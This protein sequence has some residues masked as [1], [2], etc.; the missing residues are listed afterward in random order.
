MFP[1]FLAFSVLAF[2]DGSW[3]ASLW[4]PNMRSS[5]LSVRQYLEGVAGGLN[6]TNEFGI[7]QVAFAPET[8]SYYVIATAD[9]RIRFR[10]ERNPADIKLDSPKSS[11]RRGHFF[12]CYL[13]RRDQRDSRVRVSRLSTI[14][15][16]VVN[17]TPIFATMAQQGQ[18]DY[19]LFG[20]SLTRNGSGTLAFGAID[21]SVVV[22]RSLI[23]YLHWAIELSGIS[24]NG[25]EITPIPTYP[26]ATSNASLALI[27]V[28]TPGIYGPYQDVSRIFSMIQDARL[29][30][31]D[32]QWVVPCDVS[33][34]ISFNFGGE[35]FT[36]QPTDYLIGP[37]SGNPDLCLT[38]PRAL[39]PS[40]DGLDW[41]LG[42][43]FLRTVYSIFSFGINTKEAP[44]IGLYPLNNASAPIESPDAVASF[45]SSASATI[46]TALP[47]FV[48]STPTF[49]TPPYAFNTS[50]KATPG[51]IVTSGLATSTYSAVLGTRTRDAT[52]LPTV[53]PSPTI[54]TL[55]QTDSSGHTITSV[56][57]AS[58]PSVTLGIPPGWILSSG[59]ATS[60]PL[61]AVLLGIP[62]LLFALFTSDIL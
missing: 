61:H 24:V 19:P 21:A 17:A 14:S 60:I 35:N 31:S 13:R 55:I 49:T 23:D 11:I 47:N 43:A 2:L 34:T 32:G 39:P 52:A 59:V 4:R 51:E 46:A 37:A 38:W 15:Q 36:L 7:V 26:S 16:S 6:V 42:G 1:Y 44:L 41:Q 5:G 57:T 30:D 50:V 9:K 22:N 10:C 53:S 20:L 45:L 54:F 12:E 18:L 33:E 28:G 48:L 56:S 3:A 8:Q 29:V 58:V 40:S 27:D 25:T 62:A